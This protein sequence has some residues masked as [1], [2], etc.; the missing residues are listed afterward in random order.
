MSGMEGCLR[1]SSGPGDGRVLIGFSV[2]DDTARLSVLHHGGRWKS[3]GVRVGKNSNLH[4]SCSPPLKRQACYKRS[5][6]TA[7]DWLANRFVELNASACA[8]SH[9][10]R[11]SPCWRTFSSATGSRGFLLF[12]IW[13]TVIIN[14]P[15][16]CPSSQAGELNAGSFS[17]WLRSL[18]QSITIVPSSSSFLVHIA[19]KVLHLLRRPPLF[20]YLCPV[21]Q[22]TCYQDKRQPIEYSLHVPTPRIGR[23]K[24]ISNRSIRYHCQLGYCVSDMAA[25]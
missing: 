9:S 13:F 14:Q 20:F 10:L 22:W 18:C 4:A 8:V 17:C 12:F 25:P 7:A 19:I 11:P 24:L 2:A 16:N 23:L 15:I 6:K 5:P 1:D 3:V 21:D